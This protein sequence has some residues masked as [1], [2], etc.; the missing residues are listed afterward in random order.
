M[1]FNKNPLRISISILSITFS[2]KLFQHS[3]YKVF[4]L[5]YSLLPLVKRYMSVFYRRYVI[6][7]IFRWQKTYL[8][9]HMKE[10]CNHKSLSFSNTRKNREFWKMFDC[11][12]TL[13]L[14]PPSKLL[15]VTTHTHTQMIPGG[16]L[17]MYQ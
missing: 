14:L 5:Y 8:Y 11:G 13:V 2:H 16:F 17:K 6:G 10:K 9:L 15:K 12:R 4:L 3:D 7:G 1:F